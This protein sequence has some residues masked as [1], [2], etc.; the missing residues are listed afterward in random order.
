[1]GIVRMGIPQE[2]VEQ[3]VQKF[4]IG[5]FIETG[6]YRGDTTEWGARVFKKVISVERMEELHRKAEERL[7]DYPNVTCLCCDTREAL[8]ISLPVSEGK[9]LF[10]LDA[11]WCGPNKGSHGEEEQCPLLAEL[12]L[13]EKHQ[14]GAYI[15]IDDARLFMAPPAEP[16]RASDWPDIGVVLEALRKACPSAYVTIFEDAIIGVPPEARDSVQR[17]LQDKITAGHLKG[18]SRARESGWSRGKRMVIQGIKA[19]ING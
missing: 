1:M 18:E 17:Y 11:H 3:L 7:A 5:T 4:E 15:L 2:L 12:E 9:V 8:E 13:I 14:T 19:M 10:W 16:C 6:T